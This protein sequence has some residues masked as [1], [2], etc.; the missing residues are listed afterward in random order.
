MGCLNVDVAVVCLNFVQRAEQNFIFEISSL[1]V[2]LAIWPE[3]T[4][5]WVAEADR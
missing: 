3:L 2:S 4:A 5:D 1:L